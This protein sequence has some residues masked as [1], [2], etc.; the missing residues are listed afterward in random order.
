MD[1]SRVIACNVV[2]L[3]LACGLRAPCLGAAGP[4][5]T[6]SS[7]PGYPLPKGIDAPEDLRRHMDMMFRGS[8]MFRSQCQQLAIDG[9]YVRIRFD[10]Q[11]VDKSHRA[12]TVI[13]RSEG[14][15]FATV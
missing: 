9:L 7:S 5:S 8:P 14:V 15:I 6:S 4:A 1:W 3:V 2:G 11:I 12:Q 13:N 10:P